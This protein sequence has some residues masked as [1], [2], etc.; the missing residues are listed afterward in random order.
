MEHPK[1]LW[2]YTESPLE[3]LP[4]MPYLV[5]N[6][7]IA[8]AEG[9]SYEARQ[10]DYLTSYKWLSEPTI[11]AVKNAR[12]GAKISNSVNDLLRLALLM[13]H[14]GV[15]VDI[16]TTLFLSSIQEASKHFLG[17]PNAEVLLLS[18]QRDK[19]SNSSSF[20][21]DLVVAKPKSQL[22]TEMFAQAC[23]VFETGNWPDH[24]SGS[25]KRVDQDTL[26]VY[27]SSLLTSL[28]AANHKFDWDTQ[29]LPKNSS[30]H[31]CLTRHS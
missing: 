10:V 23:R 12:S 29:T 24:L 5:A 30:S 8:F 22:F 1:I 27:Y 25:P 9:S 14:G 20:G 31:L 6:N 21:L 28:L 15:M 13:E 7:H 2:V 26:S 4:I 17:Q 3:M 19:V 18:K 16:S 11:D